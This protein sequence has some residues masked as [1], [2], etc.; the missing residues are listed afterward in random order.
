MKRASKPRLPRVDRVCRTCGKS[1]SVIG[2]VAARGAGTA[3]SFACRTFVGSDNP[4][5][6]GG[7]IVGQ[8]GRVSVYAP[9]HPG[10]KQRGG[11]YMFEYRLIAE[12]VIGRPLRDD[13]VVHHIN[14]DSTDN[15]PENLQVMTP[16]EHSRLHYPESAARV[17]A[18]L[19][20]W[21]AAQTHCPNGHQYTP[22]NTITNAKPG[23]PR[24]RQCT[25][26]YQWRYYHRKR[27]VAARAA[28]MNGPGLSPL[29]MEH[30]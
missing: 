21:R 23:R 7:R 19:E 27:S 1:F 4:K 24:C 9:G 14:G 26:D 20:A 2:S 30:E 29:E 5:W 17:R 28:L 11:R 13:E 16:S 8:K 25:R 10:A 22:D 6:R 15:R 18:R 12:S 3:C